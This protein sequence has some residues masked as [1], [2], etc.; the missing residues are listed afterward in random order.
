MEVGQ[1]VR[2]KE[3]AFG[4]TPSALEQSC[5]GQEGYLKNKD[6][7]GVTGEWLVQVNTALLVMTEKD[8]EPVEERERYLSWNGLQFDTVEA[9][10]TEEEQ[11]RIVHWQPRGWPTLDT[12]GRAGPTPRYTFIVTTPDNDRTPIKAA[13]CYIDEGNLCFDD[14]SDVTIMIF[15]PG[16]WVKVERV[17]EDE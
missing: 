2:I 3:G 10:L 7:Q 11:P 9:A 8:L 4:K 12:I 16:H 14:E 13:D 5:I 1:K 6:F 15:A 17:K